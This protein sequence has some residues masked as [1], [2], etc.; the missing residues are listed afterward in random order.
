MSRIGK[1]PI[2]VPANVKINIDDNIIKVESG[3]NVLIQKLVSEVKLSLQDS[4]LVVNIVN[5]NCGKSRS[6]W[7]LYR[8][9]ISNMVKGVTEGFTKV[10]E[11]SGTGYRASV[12]GNFLMIY[13]GHSH[14]FAYEIPSDVEIKCEKSVITISGISKQRVGQVAS[15]IRS[16]RPIEPY[17]LKGV[18]Y[19]GEMILQKDGKKK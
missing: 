4:R 13:L 14:S 18:K 1:L 12:N 17:K 11:I 7:G 3:K 6:M 8:S 16:F 5:D 9:L 10:L 19:R 15:I 2:E